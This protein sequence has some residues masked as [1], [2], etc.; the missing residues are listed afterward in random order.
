MNHSPI[1]GHAFRQWSKALPRTECVNRDA[2]ILREVSGKSVLHLG[3]ADSPF[4]RDAAR[5]GSLLHFKLANVASDVAGLD[6]DRESVE[7]LRSEYGIRNLVV[8]DA[9]RLEELLAGRKFDVVLC[10]DIIEHVEDPAEMLRGIRTAL[11]SGGT[12]IL[13][14]INALAAKPAL[15]AALSRREEVHPDHLAYYSFGTL[16][17]LLSRCGF[18][19]TSFRTFPYPSAGRLS[20]RLFQLLFRWNPHLADGILLLARPTAG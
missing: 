17:S 12:L 6:S 5:A 7:W 14:T 16:G 4:T 1:S 19:L 13:S 18:E 15:R 10:A 11:P 2:A 20:T 8:G 3:A 9:C